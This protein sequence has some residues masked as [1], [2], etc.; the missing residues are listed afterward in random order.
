MVPLCS[1]CED[2]STKMHI[3][4]HK[5]T[6]WPYGH[7]NW[8]H[9]TSKFDFDLSGKQIQLSMRLEGRDTLAFETLLQR[10]RSKVIHETNI[11]AIW[12]RWPDLALA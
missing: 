3:D 10:P 2:I 4:M 6:T 8:C 12:S 7:V 5:I 1:S 9:L 11:S